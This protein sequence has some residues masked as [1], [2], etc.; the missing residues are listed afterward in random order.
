MK[1]LARAV[2][3]AMAFL[4]L[5]EYPAV[6]D[7]AAV[8]AMEMLSA[9]LRD[10]TAR[11]KSALRQVVA[12]YAATSRGKRKKFY[13]S[14]MSDAGLDGREGPGSPRGSGYRGNHKNKHGR[15]AGRSSPAG[16][17]AADLKS[18][19]R[20]LD[21]TSTSGDADVVA[22]L[23][24]RSPALANV[25]FTDGSRPLHHAAT[26]GYDR[27]VALLL[28]RGADP[29]ARDRTGSTPLHWAATNGHRRSCELLLK[30][31]ADVNALD[32]RRQT[33]LAAAESCAAENAA[34]VRHLLKKHGAVRTAT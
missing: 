13:E 17:S 25:R 23:L 4:E 22:A 26:W 2:V 28:A 19:R 20:Q 5:S 32:R 10:C 18:L 29:D 3:D 6:D 1:A 30:A 31:G 33:P 9:D 15:K 24:D 34:R 7:D 21:Y 8:Q 12:E 27:I 14:F 16:A 11:E